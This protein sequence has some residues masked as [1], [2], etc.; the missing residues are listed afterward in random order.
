[1]C[2]CV[3]KFDVP[4]LPNPLQLSVLAESHPYNPLWAQLGD[5]YGA[6]ATPLTI[7]RTVVTGQSAAIVC[8]L[9]YILSYFIRCSEIQPGTEFRPEP[10]QSSSSSL[11]SL[12]RTAP[13]RPFGGARW[14]IG[15]D[16][17]S[18]DVFE[19]SRGSSLTLLSEHD[20]SSVPPVM[21]PANNN[22]NRDTPLVKPHPFGFK[23]SACGDLHNASRG[24]HD[25]SDTASPSEHSSV[26]S[27]HRR[28]SFELAASSSSSCKPSSS[29]LSAG[30]RTAPSTA[31]ATPTSTLTTTPTSHTPSQRY[32]QPEVAV[33]WGEGKRSCHH[34]H[35][36]LR[37]GGEDQCPCR[38]QHH[39]SPPIPPSEVSNNR[40]GYIGRRHASHDDY[41][42]SKN[43]SGDPQQGAGQSSSL[44]NRTGSWGGAQDKKAP[45]L[46][47]P[48]SPPPPPGPSL[49]SSSAHEYCYG[50][51]GGGGGGGGGGG[52]QTF[53]NSV[54]SGYDPSGPPLS[55]CSTLSSHLSSYHA[56]DD[57]LLED[58]AEEEGEERGVMVPG[59]GEEDL[60]VPSFILGRHP[61]DVD[62]CLSLMPSLAP[63]QKKHARPLQ[64]AGLFGRFSD[65][66]GGLS[67]CV[68]GDSPRTAGVAMMTVPSE[69]GT[70]VGDPFVRRTLPSLEVGGVTTITTTTASPDEVCM[71]LPVGR[72]LRD[73]VGAGKHDF[74]SLP[75]YNRTS[76]C[77]GSS[78]A[79]HERIHMLH[80][81][82]QRNHL[83]ETSSLNVDMEGSLP[84]MGGALHRSTSLLGHK[85]E[86]YD[87]SVEE[88]GVPRMNQ[89]ADFMPVE[90]P[91]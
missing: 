33:V 46:G 45:P 49:Q 75:A 8:R 86:Q 6:V 28:L 81:R 84:P 16:V 52:Q 1:M 47:G 3:C 38:C 79:I 29:P 56:Q 13:T 27:D 50:Y 5:L 37:G 42:R 30:S 85:L 67:A 88:G 15:S 36:E 48:Q 55:R 51:R 31:T 12:S 58:R 73:S 21:S 39:D 9:L 57:S 22:N 70:S 54:D 76:S 68:E 89:F 60:P 41:S 25:D 72:R 14:D 18:G 87:R 63:A 26:R 71:S 77:A 43:C 24:S 2:V 19:E 66:G 32:Q 23:S 4:S 61:E 82:R 69:E 44:G 34:H 11:S 65:L 74:D 91:R 59:T 80:Q 40:H 7:S 35:L 53:S 17:D 78:G 83:S 62:P 20:R 90:L 64:G 10:V